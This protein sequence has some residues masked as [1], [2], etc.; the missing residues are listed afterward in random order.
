MAPLTANAGGIKKRF[1][2][3]GIISSTEMLSMPGST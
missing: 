2:S 3:K 1:L